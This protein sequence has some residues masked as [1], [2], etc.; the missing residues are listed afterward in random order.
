M[1]ASS[2]TELQYEDEDI[3]VRLGR[4]PSAPRGKGTRASFEGH[5]S[6]SFAGNTA[7][8]VASSGFAP[9]N[10]AAQPGAEAAFGTPNAAPARGPAAQQESQSSASSGS[11]SGSI[12]SS[13]SSSSAA[14]AV[15]APE[16]AD[17]A[18][19]VRSPFVGTFYRSP[20]PSDPPF[21][22]VGQR[23]SRGQTLCIVE[24]MKLM[25]EIEAE[26]E[27]VVLEIVAE[28]SKP[29]QYGEALFRIARGS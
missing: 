4:A 8:G 1:E 16:R 19:V 11:G 14:S 17:D 23:V 26:V 6:A 29:V 2:L 28:N 13:G 5:E 12:S 27:G 15:R 24:A 25:N 7:S 9:L 18:H 3:V 21:V 20:S 22:E 10:A